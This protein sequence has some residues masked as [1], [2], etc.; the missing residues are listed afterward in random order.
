MLLPLHQN[1]YGRMSNLFL[2]MRKQTMIA[3]WMRIP[4]PIFVGTADRQGTTKSSLP[5]RHIASLGHS[6]RL[7]RNLLPGMIW[8]KIFTL[9]IYARGASSKNFRLNPLLGVAA[10]I[11]SSNL[12]PQKYSCLSINPPKLCPTATIGIPGFS[13]FT[14]SRSFLTLSAY[15]STDF[16]D[17]NLANLPLT[18]RY[19]AISTLI[20]GISSKCSRKR[21]KF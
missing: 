12:Y 16:F 15:S 7:S 19:S 9:Q 2:L 18:S 13:F 11:I 5:Q 6:P 4:C 21:L 14:R 3:S 1:W 10:R 20:P 8:K 17:R